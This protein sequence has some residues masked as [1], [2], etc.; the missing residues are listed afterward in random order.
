MR[1]LEV[2][3]CWI[4]QQAHLMSRAHLIK[5]ITMQF[6]RMT[7]VYARCA[8]TVLYLRTV[9]HTCT[10][11][12]TQRPRRGRWRRRTRD[13]KTLAQS[14][15]THSVWCTRLRE[16]RPGLDLHGTK[17]NTNLRADAIFYAESRSHPLV[18]VPF[19]TV[20]RAC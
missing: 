13:N 17:R 19:G 1:Q 5:N 3:N 4:V 18:N 7:N 2:T 14:I 12:S 10:M 15:C 9:L 6:T 11:H 20:P 8:L 16:A